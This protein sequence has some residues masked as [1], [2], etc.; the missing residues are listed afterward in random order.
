MDEDTTHTEAQW[1]HIDA[2]MK[3][4]GQITLGRMAPLDGVAVA[5]DDR[6]LYAALRRRPDETLT[7]LLQRLNDAIG[8]AQNKGVRTNEIDDGRYVLK[9]PSTRKRR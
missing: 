9:Q 2:L 8:L 4:G 3:S 6:N 7:A 5:G 1:A